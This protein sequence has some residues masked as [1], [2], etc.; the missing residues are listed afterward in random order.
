[1]EKENLV[2]EPERDDSKDIVTIDYYDR[3]NKRWIKLDVTKEVARLLH[4]ENERTRRA[5]NRYIHHNLSFDEVFDSNK[6]DNPKNEYLIDEN[7]SP[8]VIMEK[9][10]QAKLD[11]IMR[12]EQRAILE[13]SIPKLT[14]TQQEIIKY[15]LYD[16]MSY[17][18]IAKIRNTKKSSV[19]KAMKAASKKIKSEISD[20]K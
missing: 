13:N 18:E 15:A 1:M 11:E 20:K 16:N 6:D 9:K 2:N 14:E 3:I 10:E 5:N 17:G 12:D 4:T 7:A 19:Y 8:D